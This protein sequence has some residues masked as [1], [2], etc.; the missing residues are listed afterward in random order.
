MTCDELNDDL[1]N[2][3]IDNFII[4]SMKK[5]DDCFGFEFLNAYG[6][7]FHKLGSTLVYCSIWQTMIF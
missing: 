7:F 1:L 5:D 3:L 4:Y 6:D 2:V